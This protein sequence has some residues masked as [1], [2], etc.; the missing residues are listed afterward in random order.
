MRKVLGAKGLEV[1]AAGPAQGGLLLKVVAVAAFRCQIVAIGPAFGGR[2]HFPYIVDIFVVFTVKIVLA[3]GDVVA[4]APDGKVVMAVEHHINA[5]AVHAVFAAV[6][7]IG[8]V[9]GGLVGR[10]NGGEAQV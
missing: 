1:H 9:Q 10:V 3:V 7:E 4:P 6:L 8:V 5:A 2:A